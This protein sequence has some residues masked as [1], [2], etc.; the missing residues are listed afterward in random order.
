LRITLPNLGGIGQSVALRRKARY[1]H[2]DIVPEKSAKELTRF[3]LA[4]GRIIDYRKCAS[5]RQAE[6]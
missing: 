1:I 2:P 6:C 3:T 4:E 5:G